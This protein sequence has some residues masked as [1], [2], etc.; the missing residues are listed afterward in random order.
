VL[1]VC[2]GLASGYKCGL[3]LALDVFRCWKGIRYLFMG[4][5]YEPS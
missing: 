3:A 1:A 2:G 5:E 4:D